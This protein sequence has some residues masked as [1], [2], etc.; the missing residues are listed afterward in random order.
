[1]FN[2]GCFKCFTFLFLGYEDLVVPDFKTMLSES[3]GVTDPILVSYNDDY[4]KKF[5]EFGGPES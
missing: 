2:F 3:I 5:G 4:A 1:M